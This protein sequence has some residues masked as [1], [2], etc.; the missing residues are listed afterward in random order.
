MPSTLSCTHLSSAL[1]VLPEGITVGLSQRF[2]AMQVWTTMVLHHNNIGFRV[3]RRGAVFHLKGKLCTIGG[4][5]IYFW[6]FFFFCFSLFFNSAW[7]QL[8]QLSHN[9]PYCTIPIHFWFS[10][11]LIWHVART[12]VLHQAFT[13]TLRST[14]TMCTRYLSAC[15]ISINNRKHLWDVILRPW[16]RQ[17]TN[18]SEWKQSQLLLVRFSLKGWDFPLYM[19]KDRGVMTLLVLC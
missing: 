3:F 4:P 13:W 11:D 12:S 17:D 18:G 19:W 14:G 7:A 1:R 9:C 16:L 5:W 6:F 10:Q 2:K 8:M 15:V